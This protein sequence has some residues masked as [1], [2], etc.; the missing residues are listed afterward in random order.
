MQVFQPWKFPPRAE[1]EMWA[2]KLYVAMV[3]E[4]KGRSPVQIMLQW[5]Q[6]FTINDPCVIRAI[7]VWIMRKQP[8][9]LCIS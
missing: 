9:Y 6:D 1:D 3:D 7:N 5:I 2:W 8:Q 4:V